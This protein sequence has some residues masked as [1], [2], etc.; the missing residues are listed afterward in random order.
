MKL[1]NNWQFK[2]LENL[3]KRSTENP[4]DQSYLIKR[5][6]EL[7][8]T[9]LNEFKIEDLRI[10]IGQQI[11]LDYLIP[12]AIDMLKKDLF[13]EGDYFEGDLLKNVLLVNTV[14]WDKNKE[15]WQILND[16][17][18]NR[19]DEIKKAKFETINFDNSKNNN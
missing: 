1:E 18:K 11:G 6:F 17:I 2:T 12:L 7:Y 15:H 19:R 16:L 8:K 10:M 4:N 14:F 13:T 3:E 5:C 9:P